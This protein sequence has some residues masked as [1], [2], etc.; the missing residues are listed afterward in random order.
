MLTSS[1]ILKYGI[2][3]TW[4]TYAS[5]DDLFSGSINDPWLSADQNSDYIGVKWYDISL[6]ICA[7]GKCIVQVLAFKDKAGLYRYIEDGKLIFNHK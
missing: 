7:D 2:V 3:S 4:D 6:A 1:D 5:I